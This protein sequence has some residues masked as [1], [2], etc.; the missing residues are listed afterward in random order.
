VLLGLTAHALARAAVARQVVGGLYGNL[1][2]LDALDTMVQDEERRM[3]TRPVVVRL[4]PAAP[5]LT[6]PSGRARR[7]HR[8]PTQHRPDADTTL[9]RRRARCRGRS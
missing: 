4:L 7:R 6:A 8:P 3:G 9:T 5:S 2:A 1:Q